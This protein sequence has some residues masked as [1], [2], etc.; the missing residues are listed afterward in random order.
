VV[1]EDARRVLGAHARRAR[2][3]PRDGRA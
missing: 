3:E 1:E 2:V